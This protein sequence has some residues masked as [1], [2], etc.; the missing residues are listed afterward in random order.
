MFFMNNIIIDNIEML[1]QEIKKEEERLV[2]EC[3]FKDWDCVIF[4]KDDKEI[5]CRIDRVYWYQWKLVITLKNN[6][7]HAIGWSNNSYYLNDTNNLTRVDE[8]SIDVDSIKLKIDELEE[9]RNNITKEIDEKI[10]NKKQQLSE[11]RNKCIHIWDSG[12]Y[13]WETKYHTIG[14]TEEKEYECLI[15]WEK[16]YNC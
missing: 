2:K 10:S 1:K 12:R 9:E 16:W 15:C 14:E 3:S 4:K 11:E 6:N 8:P 13:T 5:L 7:K